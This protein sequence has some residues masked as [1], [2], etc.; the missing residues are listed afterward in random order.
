MK[1]ICSMILVPE[2][3]YFI[4]IW[5]QC[6]LGETLLHRQKLQVNK[7]MQLAAHAPVDKTHQRE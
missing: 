6:M 5:I 7:N 4:L 2:D 3:K 1:N